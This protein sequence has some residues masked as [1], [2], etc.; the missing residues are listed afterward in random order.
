MTIVWS[1]EA[2][3]SSL[4]SQTLTG[5]M[6]SESTEGTHLNHYHCHLSFILTTANT[7]AAGMA[8]RFRRLEDRKPPHPKWAKGATYVAQRVV[9]AVGQ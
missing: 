8:P 2:L 3:G 1:V 5:N 6:D 4:Q 7:G 9:S